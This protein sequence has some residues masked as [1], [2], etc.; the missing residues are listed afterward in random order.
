M[1]DKIL[2]TSTNHQANYKQWVKN[3]LQGYTSHN[4]VV[5]IAIIGHTN[6]GKTSLMRTLLRDCSFGEVKNAPATTRHVETVKILDRYDAPLVT[7]Y[8]T[9]GLED[10]TGVMDFLQEHTNARHDGVERLNVFLRA[11]K[12][13]SQLLLSDF[14]QEAKVVSTLLA[15]DIA[16]YVI[17]VREPVLSKYK[18]ELAILAS[19]GTPVLPVF[20]FTKAGS[21]YAQEWQ[22]MLARRALHVVNAFDTVAFD[23][24]AEMALW[25]NLGTLTSAP[26]FLTLQVER[27]EIWH[28]MAEEGSM[29][30][31][32]FLINVASF[33]HKIAEETDT[34]P[35]L[36]IMQR[37][38]RQSFVIMQNKLLDLY[39]FY[40]ADIDEAQMTIRGSN[41]DIFD[42]E[43]LARY[44]IRTMSGG[45][46]GMI[47]GAGIDVA[48]FG[49]SLG[50]GTALGGVIGGILPNSVTIK[51]KAM[52]IKTLTISAETLTLLAAQSQYLHHTIRHRGHASLDAIHL[53]HD[54]ALPWQ[55]DKLP[56][57]LKKARANP[58][59]CSLESSYDDK[60]NLRAELADRLALV[61]DE[62]LA[63]LARSGA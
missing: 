34:T 48:T 40:H 20:N 8:D 6:T 47:I 36:D 2:N 16:I 15:V 19:S 52:G 55:S 33:T 37:V 1:L 42:N 3:S 26:S 62:H 32:D 11:V 24:E 39:K 25:A 54:I 35:T 14:S 23:F 45:A 44:G 31:A 18:D 22:N 28:D 30:I 41:Q 12:D 46:V 38:V 27:T 53:T 10:A 51:D 13:G 9:P 56:S 43:L 61:L 50:L 49:A 60:Q 21:P 17:D 29:I 59:Y 5:S 63:T 58:H 7:L 4:D 57:P